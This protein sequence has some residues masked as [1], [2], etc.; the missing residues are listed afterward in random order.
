MLFSSPICERARSLSSLLLFTEILI[1]CPGS[2]FRETQGSPESTK[3]SPLNNFRI[4]AMIFPHFPPHNS[5]LVS[6][7]DKREI[8]VSNRFLLYFLFS[9]FEWRAAKKKYCMGN[10]NNPSDLSTE[11][12]EKSVKFGTKRVF[13]PSPNSQSVSSS[14][15]ET[16]GR[17]EAAANLI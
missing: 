14:V 15:G 10:N 9:V 5:N 8:S 6:P 17:R 16:R 13:P 2:Y 3:N 7:A 1:F 4:C 12:G 11:G